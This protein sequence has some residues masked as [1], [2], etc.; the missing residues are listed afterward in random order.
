M[1]AEEWT[2]SVSGMD[3]DSASE[4]MDCE[5]LADAILH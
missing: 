3:G 1:F 2:S 4:E 5:H